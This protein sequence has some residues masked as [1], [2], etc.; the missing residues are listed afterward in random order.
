[1]DA[2]LE[3]FFAPP[4][5]IRLADV[6]DGRWQRVRPWVEDLRAEPPQATVLPC[7][8]GD[9]VY[10]Y[11]LA[12]SD[13][14]V[15]ALRDD[16]LAFV[17][18]TCST[19]RGHRE[20]LDPANPVEAAVLELTGGRA[21]RFTGPPDKDD[22]KPIWAALELMRKTTARQPPSD[23]DA[24]RPT[25]RVLRDFY[26]ALQAS[27]AASA[28]A[29]LGYL[30]ERGRLDP[31]N[32]LFLRV[33]ALAELGDWAGLLS[34]P[35]LPDLL[36]LR[37][38][39]AVSEAIMRAVYHAE[40]ERFEAGALVDNAVEHFRASVLPRYGT[41]LTRRA[42]IRAPAAVKLLMLRAVA[43]EPSDAEARDALLATPDLPLSDQLYLRLLADRL[44]PS[45]QGTAGD[46]LAAAAEALARGHFDRAFALLAGEPPSVRRAR[47]LLECAYDLQTLQVERA[48]AEAVDTL[49]TADRA[50]ALRGRLHQGTYDRIIG[51]TPADI[52]EASA[53]GSGPT[54]GRPE[55]LPSVAGVPTAPVEVVPAN[56]I[57]WL[58]RLA[59]DPGWDRAIDVARRGAT[60]W[61]VEGLLALPG[62]AGA[63]A[64]RLASARDSVP[65]QLALPHVLT[66]YQRDPEWPRAELASAYLWTLE[67]LAMGS[68][69]GEDDLT[70]FHE[71]AQAVL[72]VGTRSAEYERL[73]EAAELLSGDAAS[74]RSVG[75]ALD[76]L[77]LMVVYPCPLPE[78]RLRF[79]AQVT[80]LF[81]RYWL[82]LDESQWDMLRTLCDELGHRDAF[83]ALAAATEV[84]ARAEATP[85]DVFGAL[86][87]R[88]VAVYT[89]TERAGKRVREILEQRAPGVSVHLSHERVG[90]DSLRELARNA[91]VFIVATA[92]AKHA[93]TGFIDAHRPRDLPTLRPAGKGTASMLRALHEYLRSAGAVGPRAA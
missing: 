50:E 14:R 51:R 42:G 92:S 70:A 26:M 49:D 68:R 27:N 22:P 67:Q 73:V 61:S 93:A 9:R 55:E 72:S 35:E 62:A 6:L 18:P 82:R 76:L 58:D 77:D 83:V 16:L 69:G 2:F 80:A 13:G 30:T 21:F 64:D 4:N 37:R 84:P 44:A 7:W 29:H 38:P 32:L 54:E 47:G 25:G 34:R 5:A 41:L 89:L 88:S 39:V 75:W 45:A 8:Y 11:A 31:L 3:R 24:P 52:S 40:L 20:V 23:L 36:Q 71:L 74:Y 86:R 81:R 33:Q 53:T 65:L 79:L 87:G 56:W 15:R 91:D 57:E 19:F 66:F 28:E 17:G 59:A 63:L 85:G 10:W 12:F 48:A 46:P 60:E 43:G 78:V 90:S 1:V